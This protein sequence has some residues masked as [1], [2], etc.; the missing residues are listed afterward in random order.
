MVGKFVGK[1]HLNLAI[2]ELVG[3]IFRN[4]DHRIEQ[5]CKARRLRIL[6]KREHRR[7]G[8]PELPTK[9]SEEFKV[10]PVLDW[11]QLTTENRMGVKSSR[12][13]SDSN[14]DTSQPKRQKY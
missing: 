9:F 8:N 14:R 5:T 12:Q 2:V 4:H 10:S 7:S 11:Y 1:N 3:Q 13:R 6:G